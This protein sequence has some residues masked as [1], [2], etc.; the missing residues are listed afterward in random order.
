[1]ISGDLL[2]SVADM[3]SAADTKGITMQKLSTAPFRVVKKTERK[4]GKGK[5][6]EIKTGF[7]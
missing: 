1:M 4:V 6:K 5:G 3:V 7:L 2:V